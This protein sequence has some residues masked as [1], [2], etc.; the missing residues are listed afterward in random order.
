MR[1]A[2]DLD[3]LLVPVLGSRV[4]VEPHSMIARL[5]SRERAR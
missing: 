3:G 4:P 5:M 2:F 1:I